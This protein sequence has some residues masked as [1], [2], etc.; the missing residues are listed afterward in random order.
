MRY[1]SNDALN[2]STFYVPNWHIIVLLVEITLI[3]V[4][5][6]WLFWKWYKIKIQRSSLVCLCFR[7]RKK[8]NF[9]CVT[10]SYFYE[11]FCFW[12]VEGGSVDER[13]REQLENI[14]RWTKNNNNSNEMKFWKIHFHDNNKKLEGKKMSETITT[15]IPRKNARQWSDKWMR[16]LSDERK[17][18]YSSW[19]A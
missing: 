8:I 13:E 18:I 4:Y 16:T 9:V 7:R 15:W 3:I 19:S 14:V 1:F 17:K 2:N 11:D 10:S 5:F 6:E 12:H